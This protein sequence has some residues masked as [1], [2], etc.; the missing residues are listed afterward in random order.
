[1]T[2]P[3]KLWSTSELAREAGVSSAYVRQLIL[4]GK[5]KGTKQGR[6]WII[7]DKDAQEWLRKREGKKNG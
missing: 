1:M 5:L 4:D 7:F 2:I 6:D 3:D